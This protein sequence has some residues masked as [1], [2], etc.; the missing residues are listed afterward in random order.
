MKEFVRLVAESAERRY[1]SAGYTTFLCSIAYDM[2]GDSL[3]YE[4]SRLLKAWGFED[5]GN[6]QGVWGWG[7]EADEARLI[8]A[9]LLAELA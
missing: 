7:P 4:Y 9:Y 6:E 3:W 1:A 5:K 8:G 2:G